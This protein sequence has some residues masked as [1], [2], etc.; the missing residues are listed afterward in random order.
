M[1]APDNPTPDPTPDAEP[2]AFSDVFDLSGLGVTDVPMPDTDEPVPDHSASAGEP[3]LS[4]VDGGK[5]GRRGRKQRD[6]PRDVP[7]KPRPGALV[8][9]LEQFYASIGVTVSAFDPA[10][11]LVLMDNARPCAEALDTLARE[12]E[13][14]R[15]AILMLTQTSAWGGVMIAHLPILV[16]IATHHGPREIGERTGPLAAMMAPNAFNAMVAQADA[17]RAAQN[18]GPAA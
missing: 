17:Q 4:L 6:E 8:K 9:P 7:P 18:G 13:A 15:R 11:G 2:S 16:M 10:C 14:V 3:P 5:R 1:S 12:N